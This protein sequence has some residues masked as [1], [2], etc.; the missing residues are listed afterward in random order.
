[1]NEEEESRRAPN[2]TTVSIMWFIASV[3][4]ICSGCVNPITAVTDTTRGIKMAAWSSK[5]R[6]YQ[7]LLNQGRYGELVTAYEEELTR[8]IQEGRSYRQVELLNKIAMI[9]LKNL[10]EYAKSIEHCEHA[11]TIIDKAEK[12]GVE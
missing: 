6:R 10:R 4:I 11:L 7:D 3:A 1:M 5:E 2:K 8:S 12:T 9:Y